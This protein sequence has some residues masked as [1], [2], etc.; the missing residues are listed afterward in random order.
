[1]TLQAVALRIQHPLVVTV[2]LTL[3]RANRGRARP[4]ADATRCLASYCAGL[5][6]AAEMAA[7]G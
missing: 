3:M 1:M 5:F 2:L 7:I 6:C 4:C